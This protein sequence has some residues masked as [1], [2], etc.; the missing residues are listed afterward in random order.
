MEKRALRSPEELASYLLQEPRYPDLSHTIG[1]ME[2]RQKLVQ[3][4]G[5]PEGSKVLEIGC[6]QGDC[7]IV[8]ADAVGRSGHVVGVDQC[9]PDY[10]TPPV[11]AG[12]KH[13]LSSP[14]GGQLEFIFS[15]GSEYLATTTK[16]FDYIVICHTVWYFPDPTTLCN[17]L[18]AASKYAASHGNT[19]LLIAEYGLAITEPCTAPHV[20]TALAV[21]TL[22]SVRGSN[23]MRYMGW[24]P[25]PAQ[26]TAIAG[27]AG[28]KLAAQSSVTPPMR[29]RFAW[30]EMTMVV[31]ERYG[32]EKLVNELPVAERMK[33]TILA[34]RDAVMESTEKLE[35]KMDALR[36]MD[37]WVASF[38]LT[39]GDD[40]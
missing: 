4:W 20:L 27:K 12:Q 24:T 14:L 23:E 39:A 38:E 32:F 36:D 11:G 29:Q 15:S 8:L 9:P 35:G 19:K 37:V 28:W 21:S 1:T 34:I 25:T 10:G 5:I 13:L 6:G 31:R 7:T 18:K 17:T 2:H 30:R 22:E 3:T 40:A 16:T 26:A 33:S